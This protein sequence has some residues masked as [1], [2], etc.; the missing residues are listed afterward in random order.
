MLISDYTYWT[1]GW[2]SFGGS[3]TWRYTIPFKTH[4]FDRSSYLYPVINA[5][6]PALCPPEV[7][8]LAG[9]DFLSTCRLAS[10]STFAQHNRVT[11]S[12]GHRNMLKLF[13]H[14]STTCFGQGMRSCGLV[15]SLFCCTSPKIKTN[16]VRAICTWWP[17]L[18]PSIS[19]EVSLFDVD[20]VLFRFLLR[21]SFWPMMMSMSWDSGQLTPMGQWPW[22]QF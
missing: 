2:V 20:G 17:L 12:S 1:L 4:L 10:F 9:S 13:C 18:V 6:K 8:L 22:L 3:L 19:D 14:I 21:A 7:E 15:C 16:R 11:L 5:S